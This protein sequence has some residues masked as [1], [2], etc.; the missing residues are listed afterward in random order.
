MGTM[1]FSMLALVACNEA[2]TIL[3]HVIAPT[4]CSYCYNGTCPYV[5]LDGRGTRRPA[6]VYD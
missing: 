1:V 4:F 2:T 5:I 6:A 3:T